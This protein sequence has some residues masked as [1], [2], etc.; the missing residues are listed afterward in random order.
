MKV[1]EIEQKAK[2]LGHGFGVNLV[3]CRSC[4]LLEFLDLIEHQK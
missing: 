2:Y 1:K 4:K 3:G